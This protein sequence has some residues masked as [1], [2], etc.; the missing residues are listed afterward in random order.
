MRFSDHGQW[1]REGAGAWV[2]RTLGH[3]GRWCGA[4]GPHVTCHV[5]GPRRDVFILSHS[6]TPRPRGGCARVVQ[7]MLGSEPHCEAVGMHAFTIHVVCGHG[8]HVAESR[9]VWWH[10]E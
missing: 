8:A 1:G 3:R 4:T 5:T 9:V 10:L 2:H 6:H 7:N